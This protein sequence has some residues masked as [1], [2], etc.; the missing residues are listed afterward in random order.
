[1]AHV[2]H[3]SFITRKKRKIASFEEL[4]F[5]LFVSKRTRFG[6]FFDISTRIYRISISNAYFKNVS[7]GNLEARETKARNL[8]SINLVSYLRT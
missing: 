7:G 6:L 3:T 8:F 5:R 2:K 1:M 4:A